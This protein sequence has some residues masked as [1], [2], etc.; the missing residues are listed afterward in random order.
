MKE[1]NHSMISHPH[2]TLTTSLSFQWLP[3]EMRLQT[4]V[5]IMSP[6]HGTS[7]NHQKPILLSR[8][9][10]CG[11]VRT[12][13]WF[14]STYNPTIALYRDTT[15]FAITSDTWYTHQFLFPLCLCICLFNNLTNI[16]FIY[17]D[18]YSFI[19]LFFNVFIYSYIYLSLR[20]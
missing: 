18:I 9:F 7:Q 15:F 14:I 17:L 2:L 5:D 10:Q 13:I 4:A 16:L 3:K 1:K 11:H 12:P 8:Q 6:R 19:Y 20:Y